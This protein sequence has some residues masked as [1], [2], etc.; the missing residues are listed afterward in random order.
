VNASTGAAAERRVLDVRGLTV[1]IGGVTLVTDV[2][3]HVAAGECLALVGPSGSGKSVTARAVLGLSAPGAVAEAEQLD[4]DG[5][6]LRTARERAWRQV[7]GTSVGYVGQEAL[8]ALDPLR[9]V[10]REVADAL[11][12]HTDLSA[13]ERTARVR[14]VLERVRLDPQLATDGRRAGTLSGGMRQRALIAAAIVGEP[15]LLVADEPTTALDAGVSVTV[16]ETLRSA[17]EAGAGVLL[18]THDMGL[19]AGWADR[20]AVVSD[21]R[22]VETGSTAAVLESPE[23]PVTRALVA[24]A[25][26]GA[27]GAA[28]SARGPAD[29]T[30]GLQAGTVLAGTG[31]AASFDG[32]RV[33]D[34]VDLAVAP[35]RTL[36]VV[37]ASGSGKTTLVRM[38]LGLHRPDRGAVTLDGD[39]WAPLAEAARRARRHRVAAVVQDPGATFDPRWSVERVLV[40]ALTAGRTRRASGALAAAV[41]AALVRVDLDPALRDRSPVSLSGGQRQRLAIAR[42]LA[43]EPGVLVLDEPVTALDAAV[44]DAVLTLLERLQQETGTAMVFVSHDL[45]AVRRMSD[46]VLVMDAGVVVESGP[47]ATVLTRPSHPVTAGLLAAAERLRTPA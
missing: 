12:L 1:T 40:D 6:D 9:P 4:L 19:V 22:I 37:G 33:V 2:D 23:H 16:M 47:A 42:A 14:A 46:D 35:R 27:L 25:A 24:A 21:G 30:P 43:T 18:I 44:Q 38:L 26:A 13:H 3:L 41:D 29:A 17:Q 32:R 45:D 34:D 39:P 5:V 28:T 10:G 7:R 15:A 20:V 31:L 36:G 8:G 11:R